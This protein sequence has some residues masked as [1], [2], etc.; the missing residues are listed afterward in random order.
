MLT[1]LTNNASSSTNKNHGGAPITLSK[2]ISCS[3]ALIE[4]SIIALN[5][6]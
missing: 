5:P 4:A 6:N 2:C 1:K 3:C